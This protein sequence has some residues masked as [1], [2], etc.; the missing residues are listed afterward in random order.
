MKSRTVVWNRRKLWEFLENPE[1][2][3]ADTNMSFDGVKLSTN[4]DPRSLYPGWRR[5][6]PPIP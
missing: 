6:L 1:K 3:F 5:R 2:M 4:P